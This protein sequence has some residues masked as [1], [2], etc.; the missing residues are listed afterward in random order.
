MRGLK[1]CALAAAAVVGA[2]G[3]SAPVG[4]VAEGLKADCTTPD[5]VPQH[6][7]DLV[8]VLSY[9]LHRGGLIRCPAPRRMPSL[10][11][12]DGD[13]QDWIGELPRF[14]GALRLD[15][16]ELIYND[17]LFD[18]YGADDGV[19]A[20]RLLRLEPLASIDQ[21][22]QRFDA[23]SQALGDQLDVPSPIGAE[24][25]YGNTAGLADEADLHEL[26][27]AVQGD[28]VLLL[29]RWTTLTD[30]AKAAL[31]VLID[32]VALTGGEIGFGTGLS[33]A[34]FDRAVLLTADGARLRDLATG[35]EAPLTGA[36]VAVNASGWTN[37][38]EA[39]LPAA[40]FESAL[41]V[42]ALTGKRNENGLTPA[43]V[44]YRAGEPVTIY[45]EKLQAI[46]LHLGI[47]DAFATELPLAALRAGASEEIRPGPGYHERQFLS[48]ENISREDGEQGR[49]QP[50]GLYVPSGL[51]AAPARTPI[52][53]WLHY[54]G[55]KAH[56]GAAWTPRLIQ[57]IGEAPGNLVATPRARGTSTWYVSQA[58]QDFFEVFDDVHAL[59]PNI[60]PDRRYLSGYSM[61]GY[62]TYLF[63]ALY[64]D[65]FAAGYSTSG[66]V[67]QGAWTGLGP[68]DF[69][70]GLPGGEVPG[71]GSAT[72]PCFVEANE[73][74]ANAQ[75]SYRLL[76]NTR[77][78]PLVIH[79]GTN[80]ELALTPGAVRMGERLLTL[81]YRHDLTLFLGY[82]HFTQAIVDEW[83]DGAAFLQRYARPA[84]PRQV[85][86][87]I[88]PAFTHAVNTQ[89][90]GDG[91]VFNYNPD[92]AWWVDD[93]VV[94][95]EDAETSPDIEDPG[96]FGLI[97]A[98]SF[99]LPGE[100]VLPVPHVLEV[101]PGEPAA[102]TPV[103]SIGA[104]S[105]PYVR[106]GL[107]WL[108]LGEKP[109][110]NGFS[111]TLTRM[112]QATL[113]AVGMGLDAAQRIDGTVTTDG[114]LRLRI[115]GF[116]RDLRVAVN[117]AEI[118]GAKSGD[119]VVLDLE[120]GT[121]GITLEPR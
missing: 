55:G 63:G 94:R 39:A 48:G 8:P 17:Y 88:V 38:L 61:G 75:L 98:E 65:L 85:T 103:L 60:D 59:F 119:A 1:V 91:F 101:R 95:D 35:A 36:R 66:A 18:A 5:A 29:A 23:L 93:L 44:A 28:E 30:P 56:S 70:C 19:D 53:F 78:F 27:W 3:D 90:N 96:A 43:N 71:V 74:N 33:S 116:S 67:T 25:R 113:D 37:A 34:R 54:R 62:G 40:L 114:K 10:K 92:G 80:D 20:E 58:H 26:R 52:N 31:L 12:I 9:P 21:R 45:F 100:N 110:S 14:G 41:A 105:T 24:D 16:G 64:P 2:C 86:Y 57:Q 47:V 104:H 81:G 121:H 97:D 77:H 15:A 87:K 46:S 99:A 106:S 32:D 120:A 108:V 83:A 69:S 7:L 115:A 49:W 68:D 84:Q 22:F 118:A 107:D 117:G 50:Y 6:P 102:S 89:R 109:L 73:G 79:H 4:G 82:E 112:A 72:S 13:P 111:A 76:E 51:A 11:A 42:G